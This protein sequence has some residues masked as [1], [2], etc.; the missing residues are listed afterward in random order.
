MSPDL[1]DSKPPVTSLLLLSRLVTTSCH[2]SIPS[3]QTDVVF[4]RPLLSSILR[5]WVP[6][7]CPNPSRSISITPNPST[8]VGSSFPLFSPKPAPHPSTLVRTLSKGSIYPHLDSHLKSLSL[9]PSCCVLPT[10]GPS[11]DFSPNSR[12][13]SSLRD[14]F[15]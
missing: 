15:Q 14:H 5:P 4:H 12:P 2:S 9:P 7:L 8:L 6:F 10:L 11:G 1:K 3:P 13:L